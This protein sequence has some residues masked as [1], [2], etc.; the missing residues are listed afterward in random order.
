MIHFKCNHFHEADR[1][2][3]RALSLDPDTNWMV[4]SKY[5]YYLLNGRREYKDALHH[6]MKALDLAVTPHQVQ[7][8]YKCIGATYD[9]LGDMTNAI[10][11]TKRVLDANPEDADALNNAGLKVDVT[12]E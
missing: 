4:H 5:G 1:Y 6:F 12:L 2:F 8:S 9:K 7:E 11:Y 10:K 3:Q